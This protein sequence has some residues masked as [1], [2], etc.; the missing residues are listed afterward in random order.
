VLRKTVLLDGFGVGVYI[1]YRKYIIY[2]VFSW[3]IARFLAAKV[4]VARDS[5]I[6]GKGRQSV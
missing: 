3:I 4:F 6:F 1:V 2:P 5:A